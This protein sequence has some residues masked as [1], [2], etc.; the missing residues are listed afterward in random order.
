MT[1][2]SISAYIFCFFSFVLSIF[3][4]GLAL[5]APYGEMAMGGKFSGSFPPKMRLAALFQLL[6]IIM[7]SLTVLVQAKLLFVEYYEWSSTAIW[8]VVVLFAAS[9][10]LNFIS[11]SK[12]ERL[13]GVPMA[14]ILFFSSFYVALS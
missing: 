13:F 14:A 4:I 3:Q 1:Y 8:L 10:V 7:S 5:G 9:F 6:L 2:I 11:T 12:K